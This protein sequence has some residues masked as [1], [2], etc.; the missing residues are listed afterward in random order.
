MVEIEP[1]VKWIG[2]KRQLLPHLAEHFPAEWSTYYEP[3]LGGG[4]VLFHFQPS[5]AVVND[6]NPH[7]INT[8]VQVRDKVDDVITGIQELDSVACTP[9]RYY[10]LRSEYNTHISEGTLNVRTAVL[11][12]WLNKRCF[13]GLYRVNK[14]GLFNAAFNKKAWLVSVDENNLRN[15]SSYLKDSDVV[16]TAGDFELASSGASEGDVVYI[17]PPYVP[18][19]KTADFVGYT[20]QGF[21][22]TEHGRIARHAKTLTSQGAHVVVSNSNTPAVLDLYPEFTPVP[23]DARRSVNRDATKRTGKELILIGEPRA[24]R[25]DF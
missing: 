17:D 15:V 5:K 9:E 24:V 21:G 20:R 7:L 1:F 4:A 14:K 3:F 18:V 16:F 8:Y 13:N 10:A 22:D 12:I 2:G 19:S 23:V 25:T 11:F 6:L